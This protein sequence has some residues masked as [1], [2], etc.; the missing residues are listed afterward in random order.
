MKRKAEP[1]R[2]LQARDH[3]GAPTATSSKGQ[4]RPT[5]HQTSTADFRPPDWKQHTSAALSPRTW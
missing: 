4:Q 1:E 5:A 2:H 3:G